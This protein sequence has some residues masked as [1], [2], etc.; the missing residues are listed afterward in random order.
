[1]V[2]TLQGRK[3]FYGRPLSINIKAVLSNLSVLQKTAMMTPAKNYGW[4]QFKRP[5]P[6]SMY[7][8]KEMISCRWMLCISCKQLPS[9]FLVDPKGKIIAKNIRGLEFEKKF[10]EL[11][12]VK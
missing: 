2:Q 12:G 4:R 9:N 6:G 11:F 3:S 1:M 8:I 10:A 5:F 7:C